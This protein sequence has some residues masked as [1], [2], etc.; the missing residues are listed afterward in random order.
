MSVA[1]RR[2]R[3]REIYGTRCYLCKR[4]CKVRP[5]DAATTARGRAKTFTVDHLIPRSK[6]GPDAIWNL[7]PCCDGCNNRKANN[8]PKTDQIRGHFWRPLF[9]GITS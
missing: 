2:R 5:H 1:Q 6:G 3:V 4:R 9:P 8:L 7:R